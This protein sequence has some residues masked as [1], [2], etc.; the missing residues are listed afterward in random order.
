MNRLKTLIRSMFGFSR[1]ETNAFLILLP[2]IVLIIFSEPI[3]RFFVV[4]RSEDFS[5][6]RTALDS[7]VAQWDFQKNK[8]RTS[9]LEKDK[10]KFDPNTAT[11]ED[12]LSLG[13]PGNLA[14]RILNY[15]V[16]K[17]VFRIK[18]DLKNI[19]G[20]DSTLYTALIPFIELPEKKI[21]IPQK[22]KDKIQFAKKVEI[23]KFDLNLADTTQLI[24]IYGIG[25]VLAKRI[26]DH[27]NKLGGFIYTQQLTEIYGLDTAAINRLNK[28]SFIS[29]NFIPIQLN[30]NQ[31]DEKLLAV[32]PYIKFKLAKTLVTYRFQ[33]GNFKAISDLT[34]IQSIKSETVE[35]LKPYITF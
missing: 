23:P 2:L 32:H 8:D 3:Y 11:E 1:T 24:K 30:I 7:L 14:Q 28:K 19:Y 12:L 10:F 5:K 13:F 26:I 35:R 4:N 31:A 6:Q 9:P 17:G 27:R 25:S 34:Q 20:M 15:R 21:K 16:K 29:E 33:H 18:S 22:E